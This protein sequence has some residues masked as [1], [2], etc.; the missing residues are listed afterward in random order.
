MD[1]EE[2]R[3]QN[4]EIMAQM[5]FVEDLL[6]RMKK[7][8]SQVKLKYTTK[9]YSINDR[10]MVV[11][12]RERGTPT[13]CMPTTTYYAYYLLARMNKIERQV[14]VMA[15]VII[16]RGTALERGTPP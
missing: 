5:K 7:I 15:V 3:R 6:A 9:I 2:E 12:I 16:I 4:E 14:L 1:L 13:T 10:I 8:E 11:V